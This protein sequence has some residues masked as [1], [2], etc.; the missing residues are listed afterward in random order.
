MAMRLSALRAGRAL[1]PTHHFWY[2]FL[3]EVELTTYIRSVLLP[4]KRQIRPLVREGAQQR[5]DSN[6]QTELIPGRKSQSG[7]DAKTY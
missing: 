3:I 5:Q 6:V 2:L 7:L 4:I 1:L